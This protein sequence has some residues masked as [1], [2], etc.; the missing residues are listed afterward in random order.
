MCPD[1]NPLQPP[2]PPGGSLADDELDRLVRALG[3]PAEGQLDHA[4]MEPAFDRLGDRIVASAPAARRPRMRRRTAL[5]VV[6]A[7][8]L[9]AATAALGAQLSTHTG[10]FPKAGTENDATELLRTDAPDFPPLVQKLVVDIPFPPGDS[11][12]GRVPRYV[13]SLQPGA[14]GVPITVQAEG[15][16]GNFSEQA[17]CAWR[18]Y[19]LQEHAAGRTANAIAAGQ[20]LEQIATSDALQKVDSEWPHY[21]AAAKAEEAGDPS[22][23]TLLV[24]F[25]NANCLDQPKPWAR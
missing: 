20:G 2:T 21:L 3:R 12:L 22:A 14:D 7:T 17:L 5:I 23:E 11:A 19:W 10:F 6:F 4:S 9:L 25:Y 13:R 18:G 24:D 15:I 16:T 1:M 8:L